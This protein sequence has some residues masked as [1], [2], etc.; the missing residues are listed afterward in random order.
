MKKKIVIIGAGHVG[1]HVARA[2]A[3]KDWAADIVLNDI[4]ED[5]ALAQ[6][7]DIADCLSFAAIE[8]PGEPGIF[9]NKVR[10][11]EL[12][13]FLDAD[14]TVISVGMPRV[15]ESEGRISRLL[16]LESM[17]ILLLRRSR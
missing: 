12:K 5:K 7:N 14:I 16:F 6:A 1:S 9:E 17:G 13:E 3:F 8:H 10:R 2:L 4:D 15:P 11:G